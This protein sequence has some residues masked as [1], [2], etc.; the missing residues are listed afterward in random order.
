MKTKKGKI[1]VWISFIIYLALL[2][3]I[4]LFKYPMSMIKEILKGC[5]IPSLSFRIA[6][7]NF[8]PLKSIFEFLFKSQNIRISVENILGNI[9]AFAPFGFLLSVLTDRMNKFKFVILSSFILSLVFEIIQLLTALGDFDVDD[10]LLNVLG[11]VLGYLFYQI[12]TRFM[13]K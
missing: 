1:V 4:I 3:K 12:F 10:I 11:A 2:I 13:K 8:I 7:S 6:N 5:E 9:I